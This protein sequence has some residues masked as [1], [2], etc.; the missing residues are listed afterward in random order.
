VSDYD[1]YLDN[2]TEPPTS[3]E[4]RCHDCGSLDACSC[5]ES[6]L[7]Q[8]QPDDDRENRIV[9]WRSTH[10]HNEAA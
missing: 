8:L 9:E 3:N 2:L 10:D 5:D 7:E 1:T 4:D 6:W